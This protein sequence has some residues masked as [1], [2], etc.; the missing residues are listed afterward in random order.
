M[1]TTLRLSVAARNAMLAA[2]LASIDA[3]AGPSRIEIYSGTAPANANAALSGNVLLATLN[4]SDP[5]APAPSGGVLTFNAIATGTAV[6]TGTATFARIRDNS[7]DVIFDCDVSDDASGVLNL[8]TV[9]IVTG[10]PVVVSAGGTIAL[11]G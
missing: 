3:D 5:A 9:S 7:G 4:F 2:L 11:A 10:G 1:A 8:N 6:A